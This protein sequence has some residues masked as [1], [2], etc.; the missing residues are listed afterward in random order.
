MKKIKH[1]VS[2]IA[3]VALMLVSFE[4][5]ASG[6]MS[7]TYDVFTGVCLATAS[8]DGCADEPVS[9]E[10]IPG[11]VDASEL[12]ISADDLQS[13]LQKI[14]YLNLTTS[15]SS[16][17]A[18]FEFPL[19]ESG[20][21]IVRVHS[22][23]NAGDAIEK[24]V[25]VTSLSDATERWEGLVSSPAEN[26]PALLE[27]LDVN[28]ELILSLESDSELMSLIAEYDSIGDFTKQNADLLIAKIK[29]DCEDIVLLRDVLSQIKNANT[30]QV[31]SILS[32]PENAAILGVT[33]YMERYNALKNTKIADT[34]V[35]RKSFTKDEFIDAFIEGIEDAEEAEVQNPPSNPPK[36]PSGSGGGSIGGIVSSP[37]VQAP[38]SSPSNPFTDISD[39]AWASDAI[40][41]LYNKGII[42]GKSSN[43]F[44]PYDNITREEF[45]KIAMGAMKIEPFAGVSAF[46]DVNS[47]AWY[48]PYVNAAVS[49]SIISGYSDVE[50][51]VGD[52]ITRQDVAVILNRIYKLT[53]SGDALTFSDSNDISDYAVEAVERLSGAG[54]INGSDG[55]FMP[56]SNCTRAEAACMVYRMMSLK[57]G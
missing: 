20:K 22:M 5:Q 14:T 56:K 36:K 23:T 31:N 8:F 44:A 32:V 17:K 38:V 13:S 54:V 40:T 57:E 12:S 46:L 16:G 6:N 55:K 41:A 51:G 9:I 19:E 29:S 15:N 28:D 42:S 49:A 10:V 47:S 1:F 45:V 27:I 50:F 4:V 11:D 2:V 34:A 35:A 26:L 39:V 25:D 24:T 33:D 37:I 43:E 53:S 30:T 21:Y 3:L 52:F 48:A 7:V 18:S